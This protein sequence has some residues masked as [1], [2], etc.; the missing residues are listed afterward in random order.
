MKNLIKLIIFTLIF[1]IFIFDISASSFS[2]LEVDLTGQKPPVKK[3]EYYFTMRDKDFIYELEIKK[4]NKEK[5]MAVEVQN[6]VLISDKTVYYTKIQDYGKAQIWTIDLKSKKQKLLKTFDIDSLVYISLNDVIGSN[7][8]FSA[9]SK[10]EKNERRCD[11][12]CLN[13]KSD[14]ISKIIENS[15][16]YTITQKKIFFSSKEIGFEDTDMFY[17]TLDGKNKKEVSKYVKYLS[18]I[19]DKIYYVS[20]DKA[21]DEVYYVYTIDE[22]GKNKKKISSKINIQ[23]I[24]K[25]TDTNIIYSEK[26][27]KGNYKW[28]D[29]NLKTGAKKIVNEADLLK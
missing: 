22:D 16:I 2:L 23:Y 13:T 18:H 12:Y 29:M 19:K 6:N 25:L 7:I 11:I 10:Q 20:K 5:I 8:Y 21:S 9:V 24:H 28:Y 17:S 15:Y 27:G 1:N 3:G 14:K 4:K 26:D